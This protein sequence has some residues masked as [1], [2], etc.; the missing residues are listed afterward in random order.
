M[1]SVPLI[2]LAA[3]AACDRPAPAPQPTA[4]AEP[5]A[6]AGA[7]A[8]R[9][10]SPAPS[11]SPKPSPSPTAS[12]SPSATATPAPEKR[13]QA[14]GTEPFWSVEVMPKGRLKYSTPDMLNG[15]V[16]SSVEKRQGERVQYIARFNG[17]PFTLDIVPDTCSD[18]MS[19][20]VYPYKVTFVHSGRTDHGC[21][22]L[23]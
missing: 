6:P 2:A 13:F 8:T 15:V 19:D 20:T 4:S 17:K 1:R 14:L 3:L 5:T 11:P 7:P 9:A 18:G 16:V 12:A 22:R 10:P 23:R 21:A